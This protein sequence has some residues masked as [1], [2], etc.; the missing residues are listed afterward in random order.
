MILWLKRPESL[1]YNGG[2]GL[3]RIYK[4]KLGY[5]LVYYYCLCTSN[6]LSDDLQSDEAVDESSHQFSLIYKD[7]YR[8]LSIII[9]CQY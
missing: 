1:V 2:F 4:N 5:S 9:K 6:K 7:R 3:F 8:F